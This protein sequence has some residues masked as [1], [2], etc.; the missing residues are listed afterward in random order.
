MPHSFIPKK[1]SKGLLPV[2]T[3]HVCFNYQIQISCVHCGGLHNHS[4]IVHNPTIE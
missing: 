3:G 4:F 1:K 2:A